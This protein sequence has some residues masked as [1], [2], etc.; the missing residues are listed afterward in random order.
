MASFGLKNKAERKHTEPGFKQSH[1][2]GDMGG[3]STGIWPHVRVCILIKAL[4][5]S[6]IRQNEIRRSSEQTDKC[7]KHTV[8]TVCL[9]TIVYFVSLKAALV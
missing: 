6:R 2:R 3:G 1:I 5:L 8:H 9:K 4:F 7:C